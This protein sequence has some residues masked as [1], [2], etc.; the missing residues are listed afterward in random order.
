MRMEVDRELA[1]ISFF[2]LLLTYLWMTVVFYRARKKSTENP[3]LLAFMLIFLF[4]FAGR[5]ILGIFDYYLTVLD[6][7]RFPE[8]IWWWKIGTLTHNLGLVVLCF[9]V[10]R[11]LFEGRDRY[12]FFI[13]FLASLLLMLIMPNIE[14]AEWF[15]GIGFL[16][17]IFIPVGLVR[18][19][20]V[21]KGEM[22]LRVIYA[23]AGFMVLIFAGLIVGEIP[24]SI[25]TSTGWSR[26]V[27]HIVSN[28]GQI[29][30][31]WL[32]MRGYL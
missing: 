31:S 18:I 22:R 23:F 3:V 14:T 12:L 6:S 20:W 24:I 8:Y 19:A 29:F 11:Q 1:I 21:T 16:F 32:L 15:T 13:G 7:S 9:V 5:L 26:Y 28:G 17:S 10:E 25:L 4:F 2:M 27:I 30:A